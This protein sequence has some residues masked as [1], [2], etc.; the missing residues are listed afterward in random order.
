VVV[1][2]HESSLLCAGSRRLPVCDP[3][4]VIHIP[5]ARHSLAGNG[6]G[7]SGPAASRDGLMF[8]LAEY[9][10]NIRLAE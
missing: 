1:T 3:S 7:G 9:S 10:G 5:E 4:R 8:V 2:G 6:I